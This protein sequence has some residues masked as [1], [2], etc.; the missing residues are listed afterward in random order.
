MTNSASLAAS[1][2]Q[3]TITSVL[4]LAGAVLISGC[5]EPRTFRAA[6]HA[7][8]T[9]LDPI[10]TTA[11]ITRT[12]AHLVYDTLFAL[13]ENLQ[14]Q[15]QMVERW[16]TSPD[17]LR[18]TFVLRPGQTWHDGSPVTAEDAIASLRRWGRRDAGGQALMAITRD[19]RAEDER[20]F[21]MALSR[22][23]PEMLETLGKISANVPAI[24]P[25]R[26]AETDAF[27]PISDPTGSGPFRFSLA[28]WQPGERAVYLRNERYV[29][30]EEPGSLAAGGRRAQLD[31]IEWVRFR[32][33]EDAVEA[34]I[35][36]DI[37]Y[38]ESPPTRLV[39]RLQQAPGVTVA[40]SNPGGNIGMMVFNH[41]TPPF[42][43]AAIRRAVLMTIDQN[44]Y[45]RAALEDPIFWRVCH[46]VFPCET[47]FEN[48][49]GNAI[50]RVA[51]LD[52]ARA[53]LR[54]A[55]YRGEP[56][57]ILHP[58]DSPVI[59]AFTRVTAE[60]FREIGM[61]V[62]L[63]DMTWPQLLER[64][65][66][67]TETGPRGWNMFHTWWV[68]A[69]LEDPLHI[70][71]SGNRASGWFGRPEDRR[72]ELARAVFARTID[73]AQRMRLARQVQE[74][75]LANGQFGILGQ[76]YEPVA[77]RNEVTGMQTPIQMY[78]NFGFRR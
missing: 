47:R 24:M 19:M 41:E 68:A 21:T 44:A 31:R 7:G 36:G 64:R 45:M 69:D 6:P 65:E 72:L 27:T 12:H 59:S 62:I 66:V 78:W 14:P 57:R 48:D 16:E 1:R 11:Y 33:P 46:S 26:V 23:F 37:H 30:R 74:R 63:E 28:E 4:L 61:N 13:D 40:F 75:V 73:P 50:M 5:A 25:R 54:R 53:A 29:P 42:N 60:R 2:V 67:R 34:L 56:V 35:A 22:P 71:F 39:P 55:G 17:G 8:L 52:G 76:F 38:L 70:A 15:P 51:N 77:F 20:T 9:I 18:W 58:T 43:N 3:S 49:A 32:T 10:T